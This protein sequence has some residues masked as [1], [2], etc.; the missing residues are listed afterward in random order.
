ME[1]ELK[2]MYILV[3]AGI[4]QTLHDVLDPWV[5]MYRISSNNS[6]PSINRLP[7]IIPPALPL[8][9]KIIASLV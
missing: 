6:R 8:L 4:L 3:R 1:A 2:V 5:C 7:R 9:F